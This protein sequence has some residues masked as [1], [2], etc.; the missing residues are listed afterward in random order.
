MDRIKNLNGIEFYVNQLVV[1]N[2]GWIGRVIEIVNNE[3]E[4]CVRLKVEPVNMERTV[5]LL[6]NKKASYVWPLKTG[7]YFFEPLDHGQTMG[8]FLPL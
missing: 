2:D 4:R 1:H 8:N 3:H 5:E 6:K 7:G